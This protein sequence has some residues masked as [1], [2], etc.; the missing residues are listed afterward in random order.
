M[1]SKRLGVRQASVISQQSNGAQQHSNE[2]Q[3][4]GLLSQSQCAKMGQVDRM[5]QVKPRSNPEARNE[6]RDDYDDCLVQV[7]LADVREVGR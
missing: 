5:A 3:S 7:A 6:V 2:K 1:A 4:I